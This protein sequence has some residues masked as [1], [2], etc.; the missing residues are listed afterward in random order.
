ML[1]LI[2]AVWAIALAGTASAAGWRSLRL[3]GSSQA[4]LEKSVAALQV[5]LPIVRRYVLS[6]AL[7][8]IWRDASRQAQA[9]QRQYT[10]A[11][12]LRQ[13]DGLGYKEIVTITDPSGDRARAQFRAVYSGLSAR[14]V[15]ANAGQG[16]APWQP[17]AAPPTNHS[18]Y[19]TRG[20]SWYGPYY[21]QGPSSR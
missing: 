13:L 17:P 14:S 9:E 18:G 1:K 19:A 7:Q 12:Y 21:G 11:D 6:L 20:Q 15:F 5:K 8:D 16:N 3:D 4:A 10:V 2:V